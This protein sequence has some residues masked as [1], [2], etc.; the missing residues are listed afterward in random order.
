MK[1]GLIGLGKMGYP[2]ALNLRDKGYQ[3]VAYNRSPEKVKNIISEGVEGAFTL[4]ELAGKLE[5]RKILWM[6][7]PAGDAID[8]MI[9]Q[10]VPLM[11]NGD[12]LI[13]G[14]NSHFEDTKIRHSYLKEKGISY[15]DIGTSGGVDGARNGAC[16]MVG[17]DAKTVSLL[18]KTF[19][20]ICV[21]DGYA[22]V[23][24]PGSG[25]YVKMVHNGIESGMM[26]AIGEG[27]EVL[28][29]SEYDLDYAK[30]AKL[31]QNGSVIRGWLMELAEQVFL[32]HEENLDD[33]EGVVNASGEGL[34]T[35]EEALKLGVPVPVIASSLFTR[36]RS[37]QKDTF[38][39]KL[40][41]GLRFQFGGHAMKRKED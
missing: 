34:W 11:S 22:Y 19:A 23:G 14:G 41:A 25:H 4:D 8:D 33:I 36:Y 2:L 30:V 24:A 10:L 28:S 32:N 12:I 9:E 35:V 3:V 27:F 26:Q 40:L 5:D 15:V 1:I 20:D 7:L 38:S 16:M 29:E 39:G 31:W 37:Q 6:M 21:D 18:E 17:G 13:D